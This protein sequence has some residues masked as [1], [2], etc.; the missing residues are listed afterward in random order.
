M[1]DSRQLRKKFQRMLI[2]LIAAVLACGAVTYAWYIYNASR[3]ITDVKMAAGTGV[4]FLISN[5]Y[6]GEYKSNAGLSFQGL[7]DPVSTDKIE[8]GFQKV[9]GF[10][11]GDAQ[12]S[13]LASVFGPAQ[14]SDYYETPLYLTTSSAATD[15]YL[16]DIRFDDLDAI[17]PISTALRVGLLVHAPG[18]NQPVAAQYVFQLSSEHN[19]QAQYNTLNGQE[20]DVL[21]SS[22][23][24]GSTVTF[25]PLT[26]ANYCIYDEETGQVSAKPGTVKLCTLPAAAQGEEHGT[27]VQVDVYVWLEG[28][29]EDCTNNLCSTN[30]Q[31]LAL[32]FAGKQG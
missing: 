1:A 3:H 9:T 15:V 2:A 11:G 20:G 10:T 14:R 16:S 8:N 7:L 27:P 6:A 5:E 18:E 24:D 22:K 26:S 28:C 12:S 30:L 29:D 32:H 4:T 31:S 13:L 23:T 19:P 21:D 17:N 25:T